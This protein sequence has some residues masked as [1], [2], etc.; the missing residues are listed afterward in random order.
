MQDDKGPFHDESSSP[1]SLV[2]VGVVLQMT[3]VSFGMLYGRSNQAHYRCL[4]PSCAFEECLVHGI[5][6]SLPTS[7]V[8][9]H[10]PRN[11]SNQMWTCGQSEHCAENDVSGYHHAV[12][13]C[14]E[15]AAPSSRPTKSLSWRRR[16]TEERMAGT[17]WQHVVV[18]QVGEVRAFGRRVWAA[19]IQSRLPKVRN[20]KLIFQIFFKKSPVLFF[21]CCCS[22]SWIDLDSPAEKNKQKNRTSF[23]LLR[24]F[25]RFPVWIDRALD[26]E[27]F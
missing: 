25:C 8:L 12:W 6:G 18:R 7:G 1:G 23:F 24:F 26:N 13:P 9:L 16:R 14:V 3:R 10:Q 15:A 21:V 11:T 4:S 2:E 5:D 20:G 27:L 19:T 17:W 22:E